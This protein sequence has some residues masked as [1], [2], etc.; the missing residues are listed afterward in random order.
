MYG[1]NP[2]WGN[3]AKIVLSSMYDKDNLENSEFDQI[4]FKTNN[5]NI[6]LKIYD[7]EKPV[8]RERYRNET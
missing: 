5:P 4:Y 6:L 2:N 1:Q 7:L 8:S 3:D